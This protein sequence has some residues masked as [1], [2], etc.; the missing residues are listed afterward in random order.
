MEG[1]VIDLSGVSV[2]LGGRPVLQDISWKVMPGDFS[3]VI[4]PNG[5]GKTT[6]L[7]VILG[8]LDPAAGT[9]RVLGG[10]PAEK[11][12]LL[13]YVPQYRTFDFSYPVSVL[14]MV[15]SGRLGHVRGFPRRYSRED[16]EMA[17]SALRTMGIADLAGREIGRLSGGQQQRAIIARALAA[18]PEM[19][20]LDEPTV[21]VDAPTGDHF[22]EILDGLRET[23][24]IVLVTHDIGALSSHVTK[25]A[26]LNRRLYT[27]ND[28]RITGDMIEAAYGCPID[29]IAHGLPHRVF[30]EHGEG[31]EP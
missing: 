14:E 30:A 17:E 25:V 18:G 23:M 1:P 21:Y 29:L 27:H 13:G 19:L 31:E 10:S 9:V 7:R 20:I 28:A 12:H 15:L 3:A 16:R 24:T 5:G 22:M 8:L 26:C 11:R 2:S 6:L 4:G